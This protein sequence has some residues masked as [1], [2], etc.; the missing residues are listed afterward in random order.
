MALIHE[1]LH[2]GGGFDNTK[3]S[4]YIEELA[5]NLFLTYRLEISVL[6]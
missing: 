3:F 6:A 4:S 1:E 2:K 5:E